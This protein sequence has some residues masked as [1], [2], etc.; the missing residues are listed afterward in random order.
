MELSRWRQFVTGLL[1]RERNL[2]IYNGPGVA[3]PN[4]NF[5][6]GKIATAEKKAGT[7]QFWKAARR[8]FKV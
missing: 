7:F 1:R 4:P 8:S 6:G 2:K 3:H 5:N